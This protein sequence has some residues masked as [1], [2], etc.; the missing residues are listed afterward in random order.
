MNK[1]EILDIFFLI[2]LYNMIILYGSQTGNAESI[3][4]EIHSRLN[5]NEIKIM[6]LN[7]SLFLFQN[8]EI[9]NY[10]K[11]IIIISTTGNGDV[12]INAEKW[13]RFIK[14]RKL[15]KDYLNELYFDVL[16]LGDSNFDYFCG[17][18]KKIFK[19]LKQLN[20][21]SLNDINTIDDVDGDYEDKIDHFLNLIQ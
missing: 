18:G 6:S 5:N 12:P 14:N 1:Y 2:L 15:E 16:A 21:I 19:R 7:D 9:L 17:A 4:Y 13:W 20:A 11:I 10:E 8:K 3:A